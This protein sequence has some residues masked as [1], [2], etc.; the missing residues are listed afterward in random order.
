MKEREVNLKVVS[1]CLFLIFLILLARLFQLQVFQGKENRLLA[2]SNRI[3][4]IRLDA[5]RGLILDRHGEVL[6][7]NEPQY[8]LKDKII[9]R[10]EGLKLQVENKDADLK[11]SFQR[12][13]QDGDVFGHVL[14]FL[15]EVTEE[16][17]SEKKFSLKGYPVASWIGRSGLEKEYEEV[18]R[19]QAG[20]ETVEVNTIGQ[21]TRRMGRILPKP[22][23]SLTLA[24]DK[25]LQETAAKA[26]GDRKGAVIAENPLN[27]EI[28][29]L[30]SSPS[31]DPNIFLEKDSQG[32]VA[33]IVSDEENQPL[34]NRAISGIYPPGSTFKIITAVA[35][36]EEGKITPETLINDPGEIAVGSYKYTNWYFTQYGRTEGEINL[37]RAITRSTDTFFYQVGERV[38]VEGLIKWVEKFNLDKVFGIDLPAEIAGFIATPEWKEANRGEK[39]FLGN[40]YHLAI[41]QGDVSLTPLGVNLMTA[42]VANGGK[43]CRP[44]M[45]RIG[46]EN[47]PYQAECQDLGIKKEYLEAIKKGMIGACSTGG[48]AW[49]FFDF[50]PRVACKTGTAETGDG[51]TSHAWFTVFAPACAEATAGKPAC[52]P[53]I[54]LTVLVEKG[55]EGSS[56][57]APIAKEILKE[58]F[59]E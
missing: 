20:S 45:L 58:F 51:K 36:L 39:W 43:L 13:Y 2:D 49:P 22:G 44:R 54:V 31:F 6:S 5:P 33:K 40:T 14:G 41:G 11:I 17:L 47:T 25:S 34:L 21:V 38:G 23:G 8:S 52:Q 59:K 28:L 32:K 18:L 16:E 57:A 9:P 48:T 35:G 26:M 27:G 12:E 15:G 56:I 55:G 7:S 50:T 19:G 1:F 3:Q 24:V 4:R 53:E 29:L 46:A 37:A 10:E 42:V 30:Y